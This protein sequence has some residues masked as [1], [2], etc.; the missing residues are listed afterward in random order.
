M[1]IM[2]EY[3]YC[4]LPFIHIKQFT[5]IAYAP[6]CEFENKQYDT[7]NGI[8]TAP[9]VNDVSLLDSWNHPH[10]QNIR[11][12]MIDGKIPKGCIRCKNR[13][14]LGALTLRKAGWIPAVVKKRKLK[15]RTNLELKDI[16][17]LDLSFSNNCNM[18]CRM[19]QP[20]YSSKWVK[21]WDEFYGSVEHLNIGGY[22]KDAHAFSKNF[23]ADVDKL[24]NLSYMKIQGG[25]PFLS[26]EH[27]KFI[28]SL[29][30]EVIKNISF[31]YTTNT[32][33]FPD[34]ELFEKLVKAKFI[35]VRCSVDG[36]G[37]LNEY[38]R[39]GVSWE[40][41][42][43]TINKWATEAAWRDNLFMFFSPCWQA[44]N[45]GALDDYVEFIRLL[46][47][48]HSQYIFLYS[49]YKIGCNR[50]LQPEPLSIWALPKKYK[51]KLIKKYSKEYP[52]WAVKTQLSVL[53]YLKDD[54]QIDTN[55]L[56]EFNNNFDS[57]ANIKKYD[58]LQS[59]LE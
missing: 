49:S 19:C 58:V 36:I 24:T 11:Q 53:G 35:T 5:N 40:Q 8:S 3:P 28:L 21:I 55:S 42:N 59:A 23:D 12:E 4:A 18:L 9:Q 25:E 17:G 13:E 48:K 52:A 1:V 15:L 33:I 27:R 7:E 46:M 54:K 41:V 16:R 14:A 45:V 39:T 31:E 34:K 6:C 30:D 2:T 10:F 38:I 26:K 32:S 56:I 20:E 50:V 44:L 57:I 22:T 43:D 47:K 51:E 37:E 29:P